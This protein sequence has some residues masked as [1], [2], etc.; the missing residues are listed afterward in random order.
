MTTFNWIRRIT[1]GVAKLCSKIN[2]CKSSIMHVVPRYREQFCTKPS[3][4]EKLSRIR[5]SIDFVV[6]RLMREY[7]AY[8]NS[9]PIRLWIIDSTSTKSDKNFALQSNRPRTFR[10]MQIRR[11]CLFHNHQFG[12]VVA[13]RKHS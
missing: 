2:R 10:T 11:M 5:W 12:V 8:N 3:K 7:F 1:F 9:M 4:A 6:E 13:V